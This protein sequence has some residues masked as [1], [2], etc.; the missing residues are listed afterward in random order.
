MHLETLPVLRALVGANRALAELKG[1]AP[2]IPNPGIL[3]DTL[4]LQEAQASSAIE[5]IVTTQ[6]DLFQ[7][8]VF[9]NGMHSAATREVARYRDALRLG[10]DRMRNNDGLITKNTLI[11]MFQTLLGNVPLGVASFFFRKSPS[12][13]LG[14]GNTAHIKVQHQAGHS[15]VEIVREGSAGAFSTLLSS[16]QSIRPVRCGSG[17]AGRLWN[18]GGLKLFTKCVNC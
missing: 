3:I 7:A 13:T 10:Y 9:P 17:Q 1:H 8:D 14:R 12:P 18:A 16:H 4:S 15:P 2:T 11:N 6:D 5:N